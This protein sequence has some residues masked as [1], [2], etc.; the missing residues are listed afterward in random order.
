M[1]VADPSHL[2]RQNGRDHDGSD[3]SD[4]PDLLRWNARYGGEYNASFTAHP[5]AVTAL[6]MTLPDG[7]VLDLA[8]GPSGSA[9]LAAAA[10]RPVT[11][12]D[13]SA[14]ALGLLG[15][16]ADR[17]GLGQLITLVQADLTVWRP[18]SVS[19]ALVLCTGYW[20]PGAF[21]AAT[22]AV[23]PDGVLGWEAFTAAA[24][25]VRPTL[26]AA[27]CLGP[28]EP[29]ALLPARFTVLDSRDL[30]DGGPSRWRRMLARSS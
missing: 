20:D 17:R 13:V 10:G 6:S 12:V 23:A 26:P 30:P 11:A 25:L 22:D 2:A 5:L 21:A 14:A 9:L 16:E 7:P 3:L 28:G 27:W 18:P 29:A 1:I 15:E 24:R 19:Y 8:S 4:H